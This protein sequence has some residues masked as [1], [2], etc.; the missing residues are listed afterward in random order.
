M[1]AT[2]ELA[3]L[4]QDVSNL[5]LGLVEQTRVASASPVDRDRSSCSVIPIPSS[6]CWA[7]SCRSRSSRRRSSSPARTMR[8]RESRSS[9]SCA[10]SSACSRSFSSASRAA[11]PAASS[12]AGWSSS[13]GSWM[14][15]ASSSP[16]SVTARSRRVEAGSSSTLLVRPDAALRQPERELERRVA[17]R[18][19]ERVADA[20]RTDALELRR[21]GRRPS[22]APAASARG[23]GTPSAPRRARRSSAATRPASGRREAVGQQAA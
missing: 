3:Q 5:D 2:R 13:T 20:A 12:S 1:D 4:L 18:P 9:S 22:R 16:T 14:I 11:E 21:R 19:R 6:R 10:R 15:A 8:A 17:D 23:R 7:P